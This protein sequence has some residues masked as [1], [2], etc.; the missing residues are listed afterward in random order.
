[1]GMY[2]VCGFNIRYRSDSKRANPS[3]EIIHVSALD[4]RILSLTKFL[5]EELFSLKFMLQVKDQKVHIFVI[6][7]ERAPE[8]RRSIEQH[9]KSLDLAY[10]IVNA[11]DGKLLSKAEQDKL[12]APGVSYAP[13]VIGCY[14]SHLSVYQK[15]LDQK[16]SLALILEDDARLNPKFVSSLRSGQLSHNFEYCLLDSD[17]A[18]G[19]STIYY[20]LDSA[21]ELLPGI[22]IYST[23]TPPV[24]LH[25]YLL[26]N[27]GARKRL[28]YALPIE[29]PIDVYW[30]LPYRPVIKVCVRPKGASVSEYS[31]QSFISNRHDK[32]PLRFKHLRKFNFALTIRDW[33]KFKPIRNMISIY[34]LK[35]SGALAPGRRWRAMPSGRNILSD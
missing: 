8:R 28:E 13:G 23:N 29:Q 30:H 14:L 31:R 10:E 4:F 11:I 27:A 33:I 12:L 21:E 5:I 15:I 19:S 17:S 26:T 34:H 20:D 24:L 22:P 32:T 35:R 1:M 18:D 9:L 2:I 6:S 16:I 7:L 25:A 3:S